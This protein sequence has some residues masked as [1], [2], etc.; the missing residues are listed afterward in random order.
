MTAAGKAFVER[1]SIVLRMIRGGTPL[2]AAMSAGL[3]DEDWN[4]VFAATNRLA[5]DIASQDDAA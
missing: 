1:W 4:L 3:E 2:Y 5:D